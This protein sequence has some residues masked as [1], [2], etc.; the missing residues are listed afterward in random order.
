[1]LP[2]VLMVDDDDRLVAAV[3]EYLGNNGL[4]M[5]SVS[6]GDEVLGEV[7]RADPDLIILDLMLPGLDGFEVCRQLRDAAAHMPVL[8][9]TARDEDFD[10]VL[11]MEIGADD[12]LIKPVAPRVLL[13]HVKAMLRRQ[14][15]RKDE[16]QTQTLTFGALTIN[17]LTREVSLLGERITMTSAEF[18]L[19]WLLASHAGELMHRD[20]ILKRLRGLDHAHE[21][22]SVDARLYR[23]RKRFGDSDGV[24]R[25]IKTVRPH[26]YL[27]SVE[28]W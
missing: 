25:R 26:R 22:R 4:E 5:R 27:F 7:R 28:P 15:T 11:G 14:A 23:L 2:R 13:A 1:M 16:G 18:D 17:R 3:S 12:Y 21:D 8:I 19:L 6:R 10:H 20:D 9:L 24:L